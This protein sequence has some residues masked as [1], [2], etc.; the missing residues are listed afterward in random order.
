MSTELL[1]IAQ[2]RVSARTPAASDGSGKRVHAAWRAWLNS[3]ASDAEAVTAAAHLY[4]ELAPDA[5]DAWLD[6]LAEDVPRL[7]VPAIAVYGPL[8]SIES[9]PQRLAKMRQAVKG[10]LP[11]AAG[12]VRR[13]LHGAGHGGARVAVLVLPLYLKFVRVLCFRYQSDEGFEWA[14]QQAFVLDDEAPH[15]GDEVDG[16]RVHGSGATAVIDELA[17][18]VLAHRRAGAEP[19]ALLRSCA[20]LFSAHIYEESAITGELP[21]L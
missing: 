10:Q 4:G 2:S 19:L 7:L 15:S 13:A 8:F 21:A 9:D 14:R 20:E 5:R 17:H 6:A 1:T 3:L 18:A 16:V 12:C 11:A